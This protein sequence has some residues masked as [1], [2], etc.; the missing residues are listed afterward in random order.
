MSL[1]LNKVV[2]GDCAEVMST[3]PADSI[4]LVVTSPP[5]WGLRDYGTETVRIWGGDPECRH[6]WGDSLSAAVSRHT[7]IGFEDRSKENYR[8]GG[9]KTVAIAEKHRPTEAGQFCSKCGAWR[10]SLGLEPHPQMFIDHL[11]EIS[12]EIKRVLKPSGTFWLNLGDTYYG[13]GGKG[14]QYE[15]FMPDKGQPNYYRQSSKNRSNWLQP[16]QLLGMP[17]RIAIALQHD[18]WLLRNDIIWHKPNHMPSSVK[19]R[20]TTAYEHVFLFAKAPRYY[21]DLDA[22]R[23]P[24]SEGTFL[25]IRQPNIDNQPGGPKT[26]ALRGESPESGNANRPI[27]IAQELSHKL[28]SGERIGK[29]PGDIWEIKEEKLTKHDIA[30]GRI[31]NFSY[32]DPLHTKEYNPK[33]K[34]PGDLWRIP[35]IPFPAAHFATFPPT[36]IEPIVKAGCPRWICRKCRKPRER[37]TEPTPEYAKKLGR[38]VHNHNEDLKR[39]MRYDKV[40]NAEYMTVGWSDCGCGEG[41]VGG[42][43]LDPFCG[44]GTAL[45]VARRLGRRFIG[46]DIVPE[47]VEMAHR[48]IR[49][50][51][52]REPPKGVAQL[53]KIIEAEK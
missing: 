52:Y 20:L 5:Y 9:H 12:R 48:R 41:W 15:K 49:G 16:K 51:K 23:K 33:G 32:T 8:G 40:C 28:A 13:S 7:N 42:I 18:N 4:D 37:I 22:I 44:S 46:I 43:V 35:T 19:D 38:S 53:T 6:E 39:G 11:V 36:L 29:N 45:R 17:W 10:G 24:F 31:G 2:V 21:F 30:V 26:L 25:R 27:D 1:P 14:G 50:D 3:W 47:Y 34:N